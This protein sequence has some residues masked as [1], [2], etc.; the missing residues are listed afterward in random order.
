MPRSVSAFH[1]GVWPDGWRVQWSIDQRMPGDQVAIERSQAPEGPW[2]AVATVPA[3]DMIYKDA[4]APYRAFWTVLFYRIRVLDSQGAELVVSEPCSTNPFAR[5]RNIIKMINQWEEVLYGTNTQ[6]N[7]GQ[8]FALYKRTIGGTP[9]PDCVDPETGE[10]YRSRCD[11][12]EG[13]GYLEGWSNPILM[14]AGFKDGARRAV[15][16]DRYEESDDDQRRLWTSAMPLLE[17]HDVLVE[18][19]NGRRWRIL[20]IETS[21]PNNIVISQSF[22]VRRIDREYIENE[23]TYPG[24]TP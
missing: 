23:L 10:T 19:G 14:R 9:C 11:T 20:S 6:K 5:N 8:D 18:K 15:R 16:M 17:P 1:V 3:D 13:T 24:E 21:E 4:D 22:D 12:C 7:V 2:S